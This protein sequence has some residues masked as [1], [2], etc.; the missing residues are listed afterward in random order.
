MVCEDLIGKMFTAVSN[1]ATIS[2]GEGGEKETAIGG[3]DYLKVAKEGYKSTEYFTYNQLRISG[4]W[5]QAAKKLGY[6]VIGIY[7]L[8]PTMFGEFTKASYLKVGVDGK[9]YGASASASGRWSTTGAGFV[10]LDISD[11]AD[12]ESLVLCFSGSEISISGITFREKDPRLT[13]YNYDANMA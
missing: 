2:Y 3:N 5:I 13:Y 10:S 11:F 12:G 4:E 6:G 7:I 9:C 8:D 1:T